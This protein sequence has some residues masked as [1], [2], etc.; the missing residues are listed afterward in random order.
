MRRVTLVRWAGG[1]R[2]LSA[3]AYPLS[4]GGGESDIPLQKTPDRVAFIGLEQGHPFIQ[5]VA[6]G[7]PVW[8]NN[9]LL[10]RSAWLKSGDQLQIGAELIQW[11]VRGDQVIVSVGE[12]APLA[13]PPAPGVDPPP[14]PPPT[15]PLIDA[16]EVAPGR[17]RGGRRWLLLLSAL[18]LL[19]LAVFVMLAVPVQLQLEPEPERLTLQGFPP[20]VRLA[21]RFLV[22]P[23]EYRLQ[24]ERAGY[25]PLNERLVVTGG[26]ARR[27]RFTLQRLPGRVTIESDPSAALLQVDGTPRGRTPLAALELEPGSHRLRLEL[28]RYQPL[29]Q[30]LVVAGGGKRQRLRLS[31]RPDWGVV[32]LTSD[33]PGA[34]IWEQD[35]RLGRTP[36]TLELASGPHTLRL[37]LAGYQ[38]RTLSLQVSAGEQMRAERIRLERLAGVLE[39]T[40]TPAGGSVIRDGEYVGQTPLELRL[41]PDQPHRLSVSRA[42]YRTARRR[43]TL[44]PG[45]RRR[46][47][48]GLQAEYGTLFVSVVPA[49]AELLVD[50]I[51]RGS[52]TRRLQLTAR[53]HRIEIRKSG[54]RPYRGN[55]TPLAG[56]SRTLTVELQRKPATGKAGSPAAAPARSTVNASLEMLRLVPAGPFLL[57]AS[58]RE[59]GRRANENLRRVRIVRPFMIAPRE[60]T[61]GA[62]R[63]FRPAHRSGAVAGH[64]L[65]GDDQPVVGVSWD[66]AARY[67]NWLSKRD[68]LEPAYREVDGKMQLLR[69]VTGGYRL[70]TEAEW[71]WAARIGGRKEPARYPWPGKHFPPTGVQGNYADAS[72][73][74]I[75]PLVLE[76][77]RDGHPV[78]APVGSFGPNPLGLYDMDGNAAEWVQD[79][80]AVYPGGQGQLARDPLGPEQGRH[81]V[82]R[83][84][85]WRDA[86]RSALRLSYRDYSD[87]PRNDLGFRLARYAEP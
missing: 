42:G 82:V 58:R 10:E 8:H 39:L 27:F 43:I 69:P 63:R 55:I 61:N 2:R 40:T 65:D 9:Q 81:H 20:P 52:A 67:A 15:G 23:G 18:F 76:A 14:G 24:A 70:P 80:Y 33:P 72:A 87:K 47:E 3:D 62:F 49:D 21:G 48:L 71:A 37:S 34:E 45:E 66:D 29:E 5:P 13:P 53:P 54:Y 86:T 6:G 25:R 83:G 50:G 31:L 75:L 77:Y 59:P 11:Q 19:L 44:A 36:A 41:T 22:L 51:S 1:E 73:R 12:A 57:G 68:G 46:L 84:S 4:I 7:A 85:S 35:E 16:G 78:T 64:S 79:Y 26:G 38:S 74:A 17:R 30:E 56:V 28:P 60:V 32:Q